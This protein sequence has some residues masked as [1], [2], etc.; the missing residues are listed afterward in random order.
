[1]FSVFT[2]CGDDMIAIMQ[3][4]DG[5][6]AKLVLCIILHF[7]GSKRAFHAREAGT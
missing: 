1:M 2:L 5:R 6:R 4:R 3:Q 7:C